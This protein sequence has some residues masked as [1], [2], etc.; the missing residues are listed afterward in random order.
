MT[1]PT[2]SD[3]LVPAGDAA[4]AVVDADRAGAGRRRRLDLRLLAASLAIALGLV[5][6]GLALLTAVTGDEAANLPEAIEEI[7]PSFS[8]TQVPQQTSVIADLAAGYEGRL[9]IDDVALATIRQDE[10]ISADVEPGEQVVY[11]AGARFEPGNATL[12]FTPGAGQPIETFDEG[13]H[14]VTVIYWKA[15]E[16]ERSARSYTWTFTT[17]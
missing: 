4:P 15:I 9:V 2:E 11:P 6:V 10:V 17:V 16:G 5:L 14:T 8:A 7:T 3:E 1:A 12:A 13:L